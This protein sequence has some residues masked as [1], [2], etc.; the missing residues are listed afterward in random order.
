MKQII[1]SVFSEI[2][3]NT[4]GSIILCTYFLILLGISFFVFLN[5]IILTARVYKLWLA[6]VNCLS[7]FILLINKNILF[8]DLY[9]V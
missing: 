9:T 8:L 2:L 7:C 4:I 6:E 5:L 3:S 1:A